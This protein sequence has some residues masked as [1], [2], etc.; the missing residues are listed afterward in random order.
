M[1]TSLHGHRLAG[2]CLAGLALLCLVS[3][4]ACRTQ[5]ESRDPRPSENAKPQYFDMTRQFEGRDGKPVDPAKCE[6]MFEQIGVH[7]YEN[8]RNG[9]P[10]IELCTIMRCLKCGEIRHECNP[11]YRG[12]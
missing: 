7:P 2:V 10:S 12:R 9:V 1:R 3:L 6:H 5:R 8:I 11:A 4:G